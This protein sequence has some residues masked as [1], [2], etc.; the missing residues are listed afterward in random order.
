MS[1]SPP[2][3]PSKKQRKKDPGLSV[4]AA[5]LIATTGSDL[6]A[7]AIRV[8]PYNRRELELHKANTPDE[9]LRSVVEN[10]D[11]QTGE[12]AEV[13]TFKFTKSFWSIAEEQQP[14]KFLPV[15]QEDVYEVIGHPVVLNALN[16]FSSCVFAYGQTGSG[17]YCV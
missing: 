13:E 5:D 2:S 17:H 7:V 12:Y 1:A 14:H 8:R 6:V 11:A 10:R 3:S 16:G 9:Y 15:E 4:G